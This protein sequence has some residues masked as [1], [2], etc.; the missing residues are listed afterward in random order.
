MAQHDPNQPAFDF[1]ELARDEARARVHQ[2]EGAP[3]RFTTD[4][5]RP[6]E[7]DA[8]FEHW[9]FLNGHFGSIDR[10]HMWHR[11]SWGRDE[12]AFGE[13]SI[14]VFTASL[15]V[16]R[17]AEGPTVRPTQAICEP[18]QWHHICGGESEAVEAWHDHA[19]PGWRELPVMPFEIR[20][21]DEKGFT[22][23]ARKWIEVHYPPHMQIP[24]APII[25]ERS[26]LGTRH[27]PGGSPCGG[28][29]LSSTS[30]RAAA[31]QHAQV[32]GREV[33]DAEIG[34]GAVARRTSRGL[35]G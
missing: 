19:V 26:P 11:Y 12:V 9:C 33:L 31:D 2:W 22:K 3:L 28:Y 23:L 8:A 13:H 20:V 14:A 16:E 29:D 17:G 32:M 15:Q 21:R 34:G 5:Y 7:L 18:C 4:Y 30:L 25:T 27:V 10:S 24:G 1:E 6:A 35:E